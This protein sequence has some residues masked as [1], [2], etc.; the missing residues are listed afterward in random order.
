MRSA[1]RAEV[2]GESWRIVRCQAAACT[3]WILLRACVGT[4]VGV[5]AIAAWPPALL[6]R[7]SIVP[8][9]E[10]FAVSRF[11]RGAPGSRTTT[12]WAVHTIIGM[13][14]A[15]GALLGLLSLIGSAR[16]ILPHPVLA[17]APAGVL[18]GLIVG[19][20]QYSV[21][22]HQ[23]LHQSSWLLASSLGWTAETVT[24]LVWMAT[25]ESGSSM[26]RI[27][28]YLLRAATGGAAYAVLTAPGLCILASVPRTPRRRRHQRGPVLLIAAAVFGVMVPIGDTVEI[29]RDQRDSALLAQE[30]YGHVSREMPSPKPCRPCTA[31]LA[32]GCSPNVTTTHL[33][34]AGVM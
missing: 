21:V 16:F 17:L 23:G 15:G 19:N 3:V 1:S 22:N 26:E 30:A 27:G 14:L 33:E 11:L 13:I 24:A 9:I 8:V 31:P 5:L 6:A 28:P 32:P 18:S 20:R 4:L 10:G 34:A 2:V 25:P 7:M 29:D 12:A